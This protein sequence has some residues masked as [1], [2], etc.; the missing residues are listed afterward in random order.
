MK[1]DLFTSKEQIVLTKPLIQK[2]GYGMAAFLAT[3]NHHIQN[4][5]GVFCDD[6]I[7]V[8]KTIKQWSEEL[9]LTQRTVNRHV[10]T[11]L[12]KGLIQIV[13]LE[14]HKAN[15]TNFMTLCYENM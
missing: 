6:K 3:L 9:C 15:R 1:N 13:K 8:G 10:K 2:Y 4:K 5:Y 14:S 7:Y 11:L 12:D